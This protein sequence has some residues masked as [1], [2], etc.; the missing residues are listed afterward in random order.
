MIMNMYLTSLKPLISEFPKEVTSLERLSELLLNADALPS[1]F[2]LKRIYDASQFKSSF[3]LNTAL[4]RLEENGVLKKVVRINSIQ[5][6]GLGDFDSILELPLEIE[7]YN[8]G[9][10]VPVEQK[11]IQILYKLVKK[12]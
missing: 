1:Y 3:A 6:G 10:V 5:G 9:K 7:D 12:T 11:N 8:L 4:T 2:S